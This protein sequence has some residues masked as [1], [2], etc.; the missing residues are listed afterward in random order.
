[1]S[2]A[3][4]KQLSTPDDTFTAL[5]AQFN[6]DT[7]IKDKIIELGIRTLAEFRHYPRT[8]EEVKKLFVDSLSPSPR[9]VAGCSP[10]LCVELM[11]SHAG[12][13][14]CGC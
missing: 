11:Q 13:R 8:E 14:A 6:F 7:R 10:S 12:R 5:A 4:P 1:M 2:S 3:P 9:S